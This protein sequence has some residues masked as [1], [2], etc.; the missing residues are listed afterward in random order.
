MG[1][2]ET[3]VVVLALTSCFWS[4]FIRRG[5]AAFL[6]PCAAVIE[7]ILRVF[8]MLPDEPEGWAMGWSHIWATRASSEGGGSG[9]KNRTG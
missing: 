2:G 6:N 5:G 7:R 4:R 1:V 9:L 8:K 3:A